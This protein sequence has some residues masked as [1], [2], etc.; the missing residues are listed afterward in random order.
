MGEYKIRM[1]RREQKGR[2]PKKATRKIQL[3]GSL[4]DKETATCGH[5]Y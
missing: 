3:R 5:K 2:R 1:S 4:K